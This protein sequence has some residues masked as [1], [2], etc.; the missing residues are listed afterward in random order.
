MKIQKMIEEVEHIEVNGIDVDCQLATLAGK[1]RCK[2]Y[3]IKDCS[4]CLKE[5]VLS[6]LKICEVIEDDN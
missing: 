1:E 5:S 4:V 6:L 3:F 2:G